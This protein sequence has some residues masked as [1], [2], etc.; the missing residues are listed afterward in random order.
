MM[1]RTCIGSSFLYTTV[2]KRLSRAHNYLVTKITKKDIYNP[3]TIDE[4]LDKVRDLYKKAGYKDVLIATLISQ[5][6]SGVALWN[7][8]GQ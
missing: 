3:A 6:S 4:D 1:K 5:R 8:S 7:I 2:S